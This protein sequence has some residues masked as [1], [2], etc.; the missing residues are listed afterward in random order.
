MVAGSVEGRHPVQS[1]DFRFPDHA[2]KNSVVHR[3]RVARKVL[4]F[5]HIHFD[6]LMGNYLG[7]K[8]YLQVIELK[9][10]VRIKGHES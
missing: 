2:L 5:E 9:K 8:A 4:L 7:M 3:K 6:Y 10:R 1:D